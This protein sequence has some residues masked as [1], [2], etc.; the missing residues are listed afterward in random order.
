MRRILVISIL[1]VFTIYFFSSCDEE[2]GMFKADLQIPDRLEYNVYIESSFLP[3]YIGW[4][5][6]PYGTDVFASVG[7]TNEFYSVQR[8]DS[9]LGSFI[10]FYW[11][12]ETPPPFDS[13][14]QNP[15][16]LPLQEGENYS[17]YRVIMNKGWGN[18]NTTDYAGAS[19]TMFRQI[20][21]VSDG[22]IID[23]EVEVETDV[24]PP[25]Q[26]KVIKSDYTFYGEGSYQLIVIVDSDD[27]IKERD[28]DNNLNEEAPVMNL[29]AF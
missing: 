23:D 18:G 12:N 29:N 21:Q 6:Y 11:N 4:T 3:T 15:A 8:F 7:S 14:A 9:E 17:V 26:Y 25:G 10:N 13:L 2:N 22:Q 20:V 1:T 24:I 19:K 27:D 5:A 28:E 16:Y